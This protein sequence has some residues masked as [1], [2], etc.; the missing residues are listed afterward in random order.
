MKSYQQL[1]Q[2]LIDRYDIDLLEGS[3]DHEHL[4][5]VVEHYR[6]QQKNLRQHLGE[7]VM[8]SSLQYNKAYL[9]S[10]AALMILR[11]IAP[12][13]TKKKKGVQ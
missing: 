7:S 12:K 9:I 3:L 5:A 4:R 10:E 6:A 13:R 2:I 8:S 11:E 1:N